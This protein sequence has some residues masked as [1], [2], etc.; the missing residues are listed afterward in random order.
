YALAW[1]PRSI[2]PWSPP[3]AG[4][5]PRTWADRLPIVG[6]LR[7]RRELS[8]HGPRFWIRPLWIELSLGLVL[9]WVYWWGVARLGLVR[10]Q[11]FGTVVAAPSGALHCQFVSHVLLV[12]WMLAASFIDID[13]KIIPDEITV[14]G[15]LLGLVLAAF[16]PM[17]LLPHVA[18]NHAAAPAG[19]P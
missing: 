1:S 12:C 18:D 10:E 8:L 5:A 9:A 15:T 4:A 17:S 14:T 13:E 6:W 7:M 3:P 19:M 11:L 2:S 16:V